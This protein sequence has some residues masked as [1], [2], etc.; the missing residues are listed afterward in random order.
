[1]EHGIVATEATIAERPVPPKRRLSFPMLMLRMVS[2]P[3]ASWGEDF[4]GERVVVYRALGVQ[5]ARL[6]PGLRRFLLARTR[7]LERR[8]RRHTEDRQGHDG[9]HLAGPAR[10]GAWR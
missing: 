2:N 8:W 6:C 4:Y 10:Y 1:M 7:T 9:R 5:T 3:V